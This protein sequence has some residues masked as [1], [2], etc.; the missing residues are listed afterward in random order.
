MSKYI[1]VI[2]SVMLWAVTAN[3]DE[4]GTGKV[5][6][7]W[8]L[9]NKTPVEGGLIYAFNADTGPPPLRNESRRVPDSVVVTNEK[10]EFTLELPEG[11]YYL[12]VL[13]K[14]DG[15]APGPPQDGDL[16]GLSRDKKGNPVK[17][18]VK[19]GKTR[20]IGLLHHSA[21]FTTPD[22]KIP[23]GMTAISG[24]IKAEDGTPLEGAVVQVYT[25]QEARGKPAFV[26]PRTQKDGRYVVKVET[27]GTYFLTV[28]RGYGGGRPQSGEVLGVYGGETAQ[29]IVVKAKSVTKGIDLQVGTFVDNRPAADPIL[30]GE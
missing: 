11:S 9:P 2:L 30:N 14:K 28:R 19:K 8:I 21:P 7:A 22:M 24:T 18:S 6:G 29:P 10:G 16:H 25:E 26:S 13:K 5:T 15:A 4:S 12:S 20:N 1:L 27:A 23:E 17:Y 3:A